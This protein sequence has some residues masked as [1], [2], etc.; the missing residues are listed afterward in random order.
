M[1]FGRRLAT[2]RLD[3]AIDPPTFVVTALDAVES[4]CEEAV[5]LP[6]LHL[7]QADA[8]ALRARPR[9]EAAQRR[10]PGPLP[11]D[12]LEQRLGT[13]ERAAGAARGDHLRREGDDQLSV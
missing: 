5:E 8:L 9:G 11:D 7:A 4:V 6:H 10:Q 3:H 1:S 13:V 2:R 12:G